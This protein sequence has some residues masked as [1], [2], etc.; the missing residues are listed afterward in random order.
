MGSSTRCNF[1]APA[2]HNPYSTEL[3]GLS[4]PIKMETDGQQARRRPR[5]ELP[6]CPGPHTNWT[7]DK[8]GLLYDGIV[9]F[10]LPRLSA[11]HF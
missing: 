3:H 10:R 4:I 8:N 11:I 1:Q 9:I 5:R 6:D 2:M 7:L